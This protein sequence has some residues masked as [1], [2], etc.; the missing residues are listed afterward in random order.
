MMTAIM[1]RPQAIMLAMFPS[2]LLPPALRIPHCGLTPTGAVAGLLEIPTRTFGEFF[3][4]CRGD[5]L[6]SW[7]R[8]MA[9]MRAMYLSIEDITPRI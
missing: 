3:K 1:L 9:P 8:S 5:V 2:E 6:V 7:F 4:S